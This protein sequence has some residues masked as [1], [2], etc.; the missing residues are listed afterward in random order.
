MVEGNSYST[1]HGKLGVVICI[2]STLQGFVGTLI[3]ILR[4]LH[5]KR[6]SGK[7]AAADDSVGVS[8]EAIS[9]IASSTG[10]PEIGLAIAVGST[11]RACL[12]ALSSGLRKLA[13]RRAVQSPLSPAT[14][15]CK[16]AFWSAMDAMLTSLLTLT[17]QNRFRCAHRWFGRIILIAAGAQIYLGLQ[18]YAPTQVVVRELFVSWIVAIAIIFGYKEV[19]KQF[20]LP[21]GYLGKLE[22]FIRKLKGCG[23][24]VLRCCRCDASTDAALEI[25]ECIVET[26][27]FHALAAHDKVLGACRE[28]VVTHMPCHELSTGDADH[29][30]LARVIA[31]PVQE[32]DLTNHDGPRILEAVLQGPVPVHGDR[33]EYRGSVFGAAHTSWP[34]S[35]LAAPHEGADPSITIGAA[36]HRRPWSGDDEHTVASADDTTEGMAP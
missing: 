16:R 19:E 35:W 3:H 26:D 14:W 9:S 24:F 8:L 21:R 20:R 17:A 33:P 5:E 6:A 29:A 15:S 2:T 25:A 23:A 18:L 34:P 7:R 11:L 36:Q 31:T 1:V 30:L 12:H 13:G 10:D 32:C 28:D 27:D 22:F 4:K